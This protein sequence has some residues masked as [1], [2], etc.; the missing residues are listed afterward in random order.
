MLL[1]FLDCPDSP[2]RIKMGSGSNCTSKSLGKKR[3]KLKPKNCEADQ[4]LHIDIYHRWVTFQ[5]IFDVIWSSS[6]AICAKF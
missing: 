4:L 3:K 1:S 6:S 5:E 2:I